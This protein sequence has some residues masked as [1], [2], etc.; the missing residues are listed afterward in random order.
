M[1]DFYVIPIM[2][3]IDALKMQTKLL[4]M[5]L[6]GTFFQYELMM[7]LPLQ[8]IS[9]IKVKENGFQFAIIMVF[10]ILQKKIPKIVLMI[11]NAV[12]ILN[13]GL[14]VLPEVY[15]VLEKILLGTTPAI[16]VQVHARLL[17]LRL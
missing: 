6:T 9:A 11:V 4:Q 15:S 7:E 5:L 8:I 13:A 10:A 14:Q 12:L 3:F 1:Q 16:I 17:S 2:F